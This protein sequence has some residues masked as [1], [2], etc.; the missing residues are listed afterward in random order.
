MGEGNERG[1][2]GAGQGLTGPEGG[3]GVL[4]VVVAAAGGGGVGVLLA[5]GGGVGAWAGSKQESAHESVWAHMN[6]TRSI[7]WGH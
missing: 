3:G 4:L 2:V 1:A 6:W 5:G 7:R